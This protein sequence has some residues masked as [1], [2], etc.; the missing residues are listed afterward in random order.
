MKRRTKR[1]GA[2]SKKKRREKER[3]GGRGEKG[4][5]KRVQKR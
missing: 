3:G 4:V 1:K 5:K 2:I